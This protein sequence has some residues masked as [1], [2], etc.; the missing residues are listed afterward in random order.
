MRPL[1]FLFAGLAGLA[2]LCF[3]LSSKQQKKK[4][5]AIGEVKGFQH[6]SVS[7]AFATIERLGYDSGLWDTYIRTDTQLVT[8][9]KLDAN[10]KNLDYFDAVVFYTTGEL[11]MDD[12][13]KKDLLAFVHD[14][15]KGFIGVHS[16]IDTFYKWP[17]Y[18]E[19]VGGYFNEHPWGVFDAPVVVEDPDFPAMK[20]LAHAFTLKDEMYQVKDFSRDRVRVLAH[21]DAN[22][23]DLKNPRVHRTDRDFALAWARDYGKGRVFY[24]TFGHREETWDRPDI[25]KMYTEAIKWAMGMIPGDATPRPM[26]SN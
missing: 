12:Q 1:R 3:P 18:G 14:D 21:L 24:S 8:K 19:M 2:L 11:D 10:A 13:Q 15:G 6:D 7:H 17:E 9:K 20:P 16:A 26:P 25:Q 5:L 23:L 22:K 4:L